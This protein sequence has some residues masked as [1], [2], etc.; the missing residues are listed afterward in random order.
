MKL[1]LLKPRKKTKKVVHVFCF[2]WGE[3]MESKGSEEGKKSVKKTKKELRK[4]SYKS[5]I[6][7]NE[8][9][10]ADRECRNRKERP[11]E[12]PIVGKRQVK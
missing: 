2:K 4:I 6:T 5:M 3:G 9:N 1:K 8:K 11:M 12:G 10:V 7:V